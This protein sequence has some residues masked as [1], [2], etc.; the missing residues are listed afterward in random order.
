[1]RNRTGWGWSL[2]GLGLA[3]LFLAGALAPQAR[4]GEK[5]AGKTLG[6]PISY[7]LPAEGKLPRTYLVTLAITAPDDPDWIVSTFVAGQPRTVTVENQGR[8]TE[9]W[10]GL[11]DNF[12]PVPPGKFAVKGIYAPAE[13]WPVDQEYHAITAKWA[14]GVSDWLPR[15]QADGHWKIPVPFWGDP[16][17]APLKDV[18]VA[19]NG[20]AVMYYQYLENGKNCPMFDLNKPVSP[21]QF[22]QSFNSGG[23]GGGHCATTDG[24]TVWAFSTDGGLRYVYRGDGKSFGESPGAARRNCYLPEGWVVGMASLKTAEGPRVYIAQAG[25]MIMEPDP[26]NRDMKIHYESDKEFVDKITVHDGNDG[27]I[28][29]QM[30]I[31][32]PKNVVVRNGF[33]YVLH[34]PGGKYAV[35]RVR[36]EKGL[37]QGNWEP[38]LAAPAN[39]KTPGDYEVDSHGRVY[40]SDPAANKVYQFD[41]KGKL[42]RTFGRLA[43][44][45]PGAYDPLTLMEPMRM[46]CWKDKDGRDRLIIVENAGPN[47]VAEWDADS[48]KLLREFPSYQTKANCGYTV[49][50]ARPADLYVPGHEGWLTRFKVDYAAGRWT[51]DAVWPGVTDE[52]GKPKAVRAN[53]NLY[54][55]NEKDVLVFRMTKDGKRFVKSAGVIRKDKDYFFWNDADGNGKVDDAELRPTKIPGWVITYHGQRFLDDLSYL[56]L[57][58]AGQDLWRLPP[59]RFDAHGNPVYEKWEKVVTDPIFAARSE[60][61]RTQK[62]VAALYGGNE[63]AESFSSDWM[64]AD[65]SPK[66]GYY[67]QARGGRNFTA[68]FGAQH[69]ISR[70]VPD[71]KGGYKLKWRV[72]RSRL[73]SSAARGELS[74][75]MRLYK[76]INGILAVIDQSRSGVFLYTD[77][78]MYVDTL[79]PPDEYREEI[80][81]YRQPGEFFVG[82]VYG[83]KDNGKIYYGSGKYTPFLYEMQGWTLKDN[84][85]RKVQGLPK[86]VA[87]TASQIADPPAMALALRGETG[88]LSTACFMPALGGVDLAG[89]LTGWETAEPVHYGTN[90]ESGQ[91]VEVRCMYDP[92]NLYLRWHV[93]AGTKVEPR[94]C[95]PLE[96][97][98]SHDYKAD[99]LS[100]YLQGDVNAPAAS[101]PDGRPGD[102]RVVCGIFKQNGEVKPVAVG[103][104]PDWKGAG[105]KAQVYRTP[106]GTA[107]YAHV[108]AVAGARLGHRI[109]E[110]GKGFVLALALPRAAVPAMK[111]PFSGKVRT[112]VNFDANLGGH[113][114]FWWANRDGSANAET[115]DEPSEARFYPGCWAPAAFTGLGDGA[116]VRN[117]LVAGPF[118]GPGAE[119]FSWDPQNKDEVKHFFDDKV[120]ALDKG[121]VNP[122]ETFSGDDIK[123]YWDNH[124]GKVKWQEKAIAELDTRVI[125]G[126]SSQ[127]W[128]GA[129]WVYSPED[130]EV[131]F[132]L[133]GH[134]MTYCRWFVNG[135]L[136]TR[137]GPEK[138]R[139]ENVEKQRRTVERPVRLKKGWNEIRFRGFCVGYPPFRLGIVIKA[140]EEK[141]WKLK[142]SGRPQK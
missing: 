116:V 74:G 105:G 34:A 89:G 134:Q 61:A 57:A 64:Q 85:V 52:L 7:A 5:T 80:G 4:G 119:K 67:V 62:Q 112:M 42:L 33:L 63:L 98:F 37:P 17:N 14:G 126:L 3:L 26:N 125:L 78:G 45:A 121:G 90:K 9:V 10:D 124:E 28:L 127:A 83:N 136:L 99:T 54:L 118:G 106:V 27:K 133:Q 70:Y 36:L 71:G 113:H 43:A 50:P 53:G 131:T 29:G 65:G 73:G 94:D 86:E 60:A 142:F 38:V 138:Y 1:M 41:A 59:A 75:G 56:G 69:K 20:V 139:E 6:V 76:P 19:E 16:V 46:A 47:R 141:L 129:T 93:R 96:R 101:G 130:Q 104:Y 35:Q 22:L 25:K 110:D 49:D 108:D 66:D 109:D 107:K 115:Y 82:M 91:D 92:D 102:V 103:M 111:T 88:R 81:V 58:Q 128:F 32:R 137:D 23:A 87:I 132:D 11:D 48:G 123:G 44:Q 79:F 140:P 122:D 31:A 51:V 18:D 24:E 117:W 72:G 68:N 39:V 100:F 77:E 95:P 13:K 55:A 120:Y 15:A 30:S 114:K 8:F 21:E 12:M 2:A 40:F 97:I 84:P 135:E